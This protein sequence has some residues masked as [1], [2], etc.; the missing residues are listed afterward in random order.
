[1]KTCPD[2]YAI[3]SHGSLDPERLM[4]LAGPRALASAALSDLQTTPLKIQTS[5]TVKSIGLSRMPVF[6]EFSELTFAIT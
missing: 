6:S 2:T 5:S 3:E 4:V 1:M